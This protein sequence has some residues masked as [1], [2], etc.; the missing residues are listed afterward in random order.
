[1]KNGTVIII[2]AALAA[3]FLLRPKDVAKAVVLV[4]SGGG[5][6]PSTESP[7]IPLSVWQSL[8]GEQVS[9]LP[10]T[11]RTGLVGSEIYY[12]TSTPVAVGNTGFKIWGMTESGSVV[13][14][15]RDPSTYDAVH[16]M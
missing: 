7:T 9:G 6:A 4:P 13:I 12:K 1:M 14:A 2:V 15:L 10:I 16:W 11:T 3:V 5:K 8:T